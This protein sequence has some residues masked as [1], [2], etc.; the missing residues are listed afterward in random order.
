MQIRLA[1]RRFRFRPVVLLLTASLLSASPAL[2]QMPF[3]SFGSR[4]MA[5]GGATLAVP[6]G[7][8]SAVD[9]AAAVGRS[10]L[11]A[12]LAG[13][14]AALESGDVLSPLKLISGNDPL[15][16]AAGLNASSA[17]DVQNA[18][19]SLSQPGN[20]LLGDARAGVIV[21][22]TGW[23]L[24]F[25]D[26]GW[27]GVYA[28]TDL[29]HVLT[30]FD[31]ATSWKNN[32]SSVAFRGLEV[33]DLALARSFS[34]LAGAVSIG[35]SAHALFGTTYTKEES[36]FTTDVSSAVPFAR[37][38]FSGVSRSQTQFSLDAGALV[39]LG[40]VR[41]GGTVI[42]INQPGF[43]FDESAAA[44]APDR[45]QEV[46]YGRQGRIGAS[47]K[48]PVAGLLLAVDY[49]LTKNET[50]V[51]GLY[52][53]VL[54]GGLEFRILVVH[55]RAGVKVNLESPDRTTVLSGGAGFVVGPVN[56]DVGFIYRPDTNDVGVSLGARASL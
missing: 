11:E 45:G 39:T 13:D 35:A 41:I 20:G 52:S 10:R 48:I 33:K 24:S 40:V 31:P 18:L 32:T 12:G 37:R 38:S 44:P 54:G 36:V 47:V 16:F 26:R 29:A 2:G 56:I 15:A 49:D 51:P 30:G 17:A 6:D 28:R 34:F 46:V 42:G 55:A 25:V 19:T 14:F 4:Q 8:T 9:N 22:W 53:R 43:S 27:S 23:A 5:M 1:A 21:A 7:I 50:L 3:G